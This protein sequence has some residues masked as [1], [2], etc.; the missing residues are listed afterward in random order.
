MKIRTPKPLEEA[1]F[2]L[3]PMIDVVL[4]LIIFFMFTTHFAKSQYTPMDLPKERGEA[5]AEKPELAAEFVVELDRQGAMRVLG[6][7][8]TTDDIKTLLRADLAKA[9]QKTAVVVRADRNCPAL[10]L[11]RLV[12]GLVQMG[13]RDWK[14]ATA[15]DEASA[16]G[17]P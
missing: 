7:P 12:S 5:A 6:Q 13:V 9:S 4:L 10:H 11:N 3:T 8:A 15:S 1:S 14:L 2:D 17:T 16:G